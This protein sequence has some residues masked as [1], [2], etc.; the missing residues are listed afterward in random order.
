MNYRKDIQHKF[1]DIFDY[2]GDL[3]DDETIVKIDELSDSKTLISES[4]SIDETSVDEEVV[5]SEV[6]PESEQNTAVDQNDI[7][8]LF[9]KNNKPKTDPK[10]DEK[11]AVDQK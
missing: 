6:E 1:S 10:K 11:A 5:E 9:A 4:E 7:D 2:E 3:F 8:A